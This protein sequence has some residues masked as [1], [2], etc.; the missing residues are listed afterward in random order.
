MNLLALNTKILLY[1]F[2][3]YSLFFFQ[4]QGQ[5]SLYLQL[6]FLQRRKKFENCK[7]DI[8]VQ[9]LCQVKAVTFNILLLMITGISSVKR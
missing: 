6:F 8:I 4:F 5:A 9:L 1:L 3:Y 7:R 2:N